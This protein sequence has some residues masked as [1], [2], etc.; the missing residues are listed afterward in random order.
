[1]YIK[2][3]LL[4]VSTSWIDANLS[5]TSSTFSGSNFTNLS[6]KL[7]TILSLSP[8]KSL[9]LY[10]VSK[11]QS[12][13]E[14]INSPV[15]EMTVLKS[16]FFNSLDISFIDTYNWLSSPSLLLIKPGNIST[17]TGIINPNISSSD[18]SWNTWLIIS[19]SRLSSIS[20]LKPSSL[21]I[22]G[23]IKS[24]NI[25]DVPFASVWI[26]LRTDI[27]ESLKSIATRL[28]NILL[29]N[30]TPPNLILNNL[31]AAVLRYIANHWSN[32]SSWKLAILAL[33]LSKR[34]TSLLIVK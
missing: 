31:P 23:S 1:M 33:S 28:S 15:W 9:G 13:S 19:L 14:A 24:L 32:W 22:K 4:I 18:I 26:S 5:N 30:S 29:S 8:N 6:K 7:E 17:E 20:A 21:D 2:P 12:Y 34:I 16:T 25:T 27:F 10:P 11:I 3:I